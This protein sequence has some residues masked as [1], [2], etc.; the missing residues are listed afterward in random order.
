MI[1]NAGRQRN[2]CP[3][4]IERSGD[5][6]PSNAACLSPSNRCPHCI[7]RTPSSPVRKTVPKRRSARR[8]VR[9]F[10]NR[11]RPS[12]QYPRCRPARRKQT[13]GCIRMLGRP[14]KRRR[15]RFESDSRR[16]DQGFCFRASKPLGELKQV[17]TRFKFSF[18]PVTSSQQPNPLHNS[19]FDQGAARVAC[20]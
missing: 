14:P 7:R 13:G 18:G 1:R 11:Q 16:I 4:H 3:L 9:E 2:P 8:I 5:L 12:L 6:R 15:Q 17:A 10:P 20:D 19:A